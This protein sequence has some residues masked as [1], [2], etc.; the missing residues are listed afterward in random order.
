MS[1][2]IKLVPTAVVMDLGESVCAR[3]RRLTT[4]LTAQV[5]QALRAKIALAAADGP[6]NAAIARERNVS[7]TTVR[8]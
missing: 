2:T 4:S 7:V 5:R 1:R 3:L 8:T 6:T